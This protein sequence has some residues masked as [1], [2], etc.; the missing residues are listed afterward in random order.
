MLDYIKQ[1]WAEI[2]LNNLNYNISNIKS[3]LPNETE[4]IAVVKAD[5]YGHGDYYISNEL[6]NNGVHFLAVSS[7][8]EARSLRRHGIACDILILG[9]TPPNMACY[10]AE[11]NITQTIFSPEYAKEL[12]HYATLNNHTINVHIKLDTGMSRI[13]FDCNDENFHHIISLFSMNA[14][15]I[16]GVYTHLS[17][18]DSLD[19]CSKNYTQMQLNIYNKII[20]KLK[21][22]NSPCFS[23]HIQ[24]SAGISFIN[25]VSYDYA[26]AG[27]VI[28]GVPPSNEKLNID[29][30]P[31]MSVKSVVSMVKTL[32]SGVALSY[33]RTFT[34]TKK[35][36]I[37]TVP[38]GYA[39]G[40]PRLLSNT[41]YMLVRGQRANI[42]GNICMD[43]LLLDV[44]DIDDVCQGDVVTVIGTDGNNS[45]TFWELANLIGAIGYELMCSIDK[46]VP[47]VYFRDGKCVEVLDYTQIIM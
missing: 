30:R 32:E 18:A 10:I 28:Y 1:T 17:S 24:N 19:D 23:T 46:R 31:V 29:I 15:N 6:I 4:L 26:R 37:A 34:T 36:K 35:T 47:R 39:D 16:N 11:L 45:I 25:D 22:E 42:I 40:Y 44:T 2:N 8:A 13:G 14:L 41:G 12:S 38:I 27:I 43:Q 21:S 33:S 20:E 7:L 9:Y 3:K 5:A